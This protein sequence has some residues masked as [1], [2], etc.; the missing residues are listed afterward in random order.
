MPVPPLHHGIHCAGIHGVRL[1]E[2]YR[3]RRAVDQVEHGHGD[4]EGAVKP[5]RDV[6]MGRFALSDSAKKHISVRNPDNGNEHINGPLEFGI[7]F[8]ACHAQGQ[9]DGRRDDDSLPTP[10]GKGGQTI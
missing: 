2:R 9:S 3:E 8:S 10:E 6:D 5:V 4:N 7:F 1:S